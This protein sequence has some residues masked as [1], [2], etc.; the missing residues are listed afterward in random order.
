MLFV[1]Y[2]G[3][4]MPRSC[5][6]NTILGCHAAIVQQ[7]PCHT[8]LFLILPVHFLGSTTTKR[9]WRPK[10]HLPASEP[11]CSRASEPRRSFP[12]PELLCT[13]Q[14]QSHRTTLCTYRISRRDRA[15][16]T[17]LCPS[18]CMK[19]QCLSRKKYSLVKTALCSSYCNSSKGLITSCSAL[20]SAPGLRKE[21]VFVSTNL[22]AMRYSDCRHRFLQKVFFILD[23]SF[24]NSLHRK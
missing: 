18:H 23:H 5:D 14:Y 15:H 3:N 21:L 22:P 7:E 1:C 4:T 24:Q 11:V 17:A 12:V 6:F 2:F 16:H 10:E 19:H 20:Y 8:N 9:G 13:I